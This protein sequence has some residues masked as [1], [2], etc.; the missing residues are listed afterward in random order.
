MNHDFNPYTSVNVVRLNCCTAELGI[1]E[2]E[3]V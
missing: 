3:T 1:G 2:G